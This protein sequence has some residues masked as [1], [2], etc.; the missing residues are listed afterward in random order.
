[1][2]QKI[3]K[4]WL[5]TGITNEIH[6]KLRDTIGNLVTLS[7]AL[8]KEVSQSLFSEK[9]PKYAVKS[10][11]SLARKLASEYDEWTAATIVARSE[12]IGNWMIERWPR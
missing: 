10:K 7:E 1:M 9:K 8:N 11:Y 12:K 5:D 6:E 4:E 3:T 2:P